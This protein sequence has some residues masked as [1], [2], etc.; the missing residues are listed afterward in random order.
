MVRALNYKLGGLHLV[1]I[2]PWHQTEFVIGSAY[3]LTEKSAWDAAELPHQL[4]FESKKGQ[5]C[6]AWVWNGEG[7]EKLVIVSNIPFGS[8]QPEWTDYLKTYSS[9][10]GW[11]FR[12]VTLPF[13]FHP[14]FPKFSVKWQAP[15]KSRVQIS[16]PRFLNSQLIRLVPFDILYLVMFHFNLLVS[17]SLIQKPNDGRE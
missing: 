2:P 7:T 13:T 12:K 14:E 4:R 16:W 11:N 6:V 8:Y 15:R 5:I 17:Q 9:I 3:H 1:Q 10:F